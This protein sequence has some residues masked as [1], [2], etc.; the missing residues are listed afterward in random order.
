MLAIL[1][2]LV[3]FWFTGRTEEKQ[4]TI[5]GIDLKDVEGKLIMRLTQLVKIK[6]NKVIFFTE[7]PETFFVPYAVYGA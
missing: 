4:L 1:L 2:A 3:L 5:L 7:N 6:M